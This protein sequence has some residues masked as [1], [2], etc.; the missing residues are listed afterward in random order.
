LHFSTGLDL[1]ENLCRYATL[2]R[3]C[4]GGAVLCVI[5]INNT[6]CR[7]YPTPP[8]V[9]KFLK[10]DCY[11]LSCLMWFDGKR[12]FGQP[13]VSSL[14]NSGVAYG[15]KIV[16]SL[17]A[18]PK[19]HIWYMHSSGQY[20]RFWRGYQNLKVKVRSRSKVKMG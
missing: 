17:H 10:I 15:Q 19:H 11:R 4:A 12:N 18:G 2:V 14:V 5:V 1:S 9:F 3:R 20:K 13:N 7:K 16:K 8:A 6:V